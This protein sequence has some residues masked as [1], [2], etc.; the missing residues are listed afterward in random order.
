MSGRRMQSACAMCAS[1]ASSSTLLATQPQAHISPGT[2]QTVSCWSVLLSSGQITLKGLSEVGLA[3]TLPAS[4]QHQHS[5]CRCQR[6]AESG[7]KVARPP[8]PSTR[9]VN[10]LLQAPTLQPAHSTGTTAPAPALSTGTRPCVTP[11]RVLQWHIKWTVTV[12]PSWSDSTAVW[13]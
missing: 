5:P 8:Y 11:S 2:V 7:E 6:G 9:G 10:L 13:L 1:A 4:I 3:R 12:V